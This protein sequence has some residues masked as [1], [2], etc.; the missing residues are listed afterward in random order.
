MTSSGFE[1]LLPDDDNYFDSYGISVQN[2]SYGT[3]IENYYGIESMA[4]DESCTR[5]HELVHVFSSGNEGN[6]S[7]VEGT[8]AGLTGWANITGQFKQSKNTITVGATDSLAQVVEL[9]S[10]GP[11]YDGRIKPE[12]VAFG[13]GGTSGAAALVSGLCLLLQYEFQ[14]IHAGTLPPASLLKAILINTAKD[15]G[16]PGPDFESGF[17]SVRANEAVKSIDE[18]KFSIDHIVEGETIAIPLSVPNGISQFKVTLAWADPAAPAEAA[19]ALINDLDL[20]VKNVNSGEV[21]LPWVLSVFPHADSLIL[22]ARR[23]LDTINNIEQITLLAPA[24]GEYEIVVK[25]KK[26]ISGTQEFSLTWLTETSDDFQWTFPSASDNLL[27]GK[28]NILRWTGGGNLK[29]II[30]YKGPEQDTWQAVVSDINVSAGS[31]H[32]NTPMQ[33]GLMQLRWTNA[34]TFFLSDTFVLGDPVRPK[35]GFVCPDSI[36]FYWNAAQDADS[37]EI[38]ALGQKHLEHL[39][40]TTDTFYIANKPDGYGFVYAVAPVYAGVTGPRSFGFDYRAQGAGCY[41]DNF[42]LRYIQDSTAYFE[43]NLGTLYNVES[44]ILERLDGD[45][46]QT[47]LT[48]SPVTDTKLQFVTTELSQGVNYFH[49]VVVLK[50]EKRISGGDVIVYYAADQEILAFP[51]PANRGYDMQVL[52]KRNESY[53]LKIF[54]ILGRELTSYTAPDNP[55][56]IDVTGFAAGTYFLVIQY[57]SGGIASESIIIRN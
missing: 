26:I 32:W 43:A 35:V 54:D 16:R 47:I 55:Q 50:N 5:L 20:E 8:Y 33:S 52:V 9:S 30:E 17:G 28:K 53:T 24:P 22:T 44:V 49:L 14:K 48:I 7:P 25:G 40:Y 21:I 57:E 11:A 23:G 51:N 29:G 27:P 4:Y 3:G 12:L 6:S 46:Y 18:N 42:F 1:V 56:T 2:H 36:L 38:L 37:F 19:K 45:T 10:S 13:Q 39:D 41:I 34:D 31:A 15:V